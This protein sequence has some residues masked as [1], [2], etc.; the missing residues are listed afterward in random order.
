VHHERVTRAELLRRAAV[1]AAGLA[2]GGSGAYAL[3][4]A[5][6]DD[7]TAKVLTQPA[8]G[9]VHRFRSRPDLRPPVV[10]VVQNR[11][12]TGKGY[13][14]LS[15]SSGPGQRGPMIVDNSGNVVWFRS[16]AGTRKALNLR[17]ALYEGKPVL[18]WWEGEVGKEG[19]GLGEHVIVDSSYR[20]VARFPAGNRRGGD[21]HE[22]VLTPDGTALVTAWTKVTRNLL[23]RGGRRHHAVI[24]GIAQELEIP[25]ARVLFEW[26]STDHVSLAE[27]HAPVAP[28][29]DFFHINSIDVAPDGDWIVSAR[30]TWAIYKISRKTGEIVW[31]LGGKKS[32]FAMGPGTQFAWQ[33][34][35]RAHRDGTVI[36]LFDDGAAPPVEPQSRGLV[37]KLDEA[38]RRATLERLY[39]HR[40][41]R[42]LAHYMGS[43]QVL[44]NGNAVIGW[45]SEPYLTEFGGDGS[46]V[47]DARLPRAGQTYRVVRMPWAGRPVRRPTLV[48]HRVNGSRRLYASWNGATELAQWHLR[49]G[50]RASNVRDAATVP[51]TGFE[52]SIELL[53]RST[54]A[55]VVALDTAGRPLSRS[56]TIR[57]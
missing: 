30:N 6:E 22:F 39:R 17:S 47:F 27:T 29:F 50:S 12:S 35:A 28:R 13:L 37:I 41:N 1:G 24:D 55:E 34:D 15:P 19:L 38:G 14:L 33:H 36:S 11:G 18:T 21:L 52:T 56:K 43:M 42:L 44:E 53:D 46:I 16:L 40:P 2:A 54:Y 48:G 4:R 45:G 26:R 7:A 51:A 25:S 3:V 57:V 10:S 31:R 9:K 8:A 49:T 20:D 32:D 23:G 5:L